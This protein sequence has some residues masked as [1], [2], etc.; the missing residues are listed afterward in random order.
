[1]MPLV[2]LIAAVAA[3]VVGFLVIRTKG[4][5]FIM[6]T[7]AFGQ[8]LYYFVNTSR[9]TGGPTGSSSCSGPAWRSAGPCCSTST[10]R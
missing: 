2:M 4:I 1:M 10:T 6:T 7:L 5:F 3:L 8:M 9:H